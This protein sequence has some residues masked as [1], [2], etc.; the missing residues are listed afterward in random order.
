MKL[1]N[2]PIKVL[3]KYVSEIINTYKKA[4][5]ECLVDINK[6]HERKYYLKFLEDDVKALSAKEY[7]LAIE[8]IIGSLKKEE[9]EIIENMF[10]KENN[11]PFWYLETLSRSTYYR[12][13]RKSLEN[14]LYYF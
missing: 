8:S 7:I 11:N 3:S 5:I 13:K 1:K 6:A 14:F 9:Q 10:I 4:K 2:E 12:Y